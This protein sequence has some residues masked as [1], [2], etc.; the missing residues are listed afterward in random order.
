MKLCKERCPRKSTPDGDNSS[1]L[2]VIRSLWVPMCFEWKTRRKNEI[3]W[4]QV[5]SLSWPSLLLVHPLKKAEIWFRS[6]NILSALWVSL[7]LQAIK[8][9]VSSWDWMLSFCFD[10]LKP[11]SSEWVIKYTK[12][13]NMAHPTHCVLPNRKGSDKTLGSWCPEGPQHP[14]GG[15]W[16]TKWRGK[17]GDRNFK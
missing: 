16:E 5:C 7:S 11:C 17:Q 4:R 15:G 10:L 6:L 12:Y 8:K 1:T 13:G 14:G 3:P 2:L 9:Q